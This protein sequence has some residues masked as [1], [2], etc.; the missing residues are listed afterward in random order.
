[1]GSLDLEVDRIR[2][3]A[4]DPGGVATVA[5]VEARWR[6]RWPSDPGREPASGLTLIVFRR[7]SR[8]W[9]IVQDASL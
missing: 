2:I 6:I 1:M 3:L 9:E 8:G 5:S 4:R 7:A